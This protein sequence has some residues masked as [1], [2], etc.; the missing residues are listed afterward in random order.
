MNRGARGER[1]GSEQTGASHRTGLRTKAIN[2][3]RRVPGFWSNAPCWESH[4]QDPRGAGV[5]GAAGDG[6]T[7]P[8]TSSPLAALLR[9]ESSDLPA[10]GRY[11]YAAAARITMTTAV[12]SFMN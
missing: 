6:R 7:G 5:A 3:L 1:G 10:C 8:D 12:R 2:Y 4:I 9:V 11:L